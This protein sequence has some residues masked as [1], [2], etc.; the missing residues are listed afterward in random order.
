VKTM[1]DFYIYMLISE[2]R[3]QRVTNYEFYHLVYDWCFILCG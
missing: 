2:T 3:N 1:Q